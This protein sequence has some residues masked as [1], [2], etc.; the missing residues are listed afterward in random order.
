MTMRKPDDAAKLYHERRAV[1][2]QFVKTALDP[3]GTLLA[4]LPE[5]VDQLDD[6]DLDKLAEIVVKIAR[7]NQKFRGV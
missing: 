7:L 3:S 2:E 5:V 6:A 4:A 1:T